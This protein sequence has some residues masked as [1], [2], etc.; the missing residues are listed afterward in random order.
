MWSSSHCRKLVT[1]NLRRTDVDS[2]YKITGWH[3]F[4]V[5]LPG[6]VVGQTVTVRRATPSPPIIAAR[7]VSTPGARIVAVARTYV[8]RSPYVEGGASPRGFDCSGYSMYS[9]AHAHVAALPHNAEAQRHAAHMHQISSSSAR[10]G[11]LVFYMSG[12]VAYH[13]AVYAGHGN[14]YAAATPSA[15][16]VYQRVWSSAVQ[17][18]TDWH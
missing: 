6:S 9:Y 5:T 17:Y 3:G 1:A 13:V 8:G 14:Q 18:R 2:R 4:R 15:G 10:P 11:D 16:L 12:G 7:V